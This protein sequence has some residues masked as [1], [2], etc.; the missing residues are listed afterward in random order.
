MWAW[1]FWWTVN[2]RK[3]KSK[4]SPK[5]RNPR[6][7]LT[8][9]P[10]RTTISYPP[11]SRKN[12]YRQHLREG[13]QPPVFC[14]AHITPRRS[15]W[16][17]RTRKPL[18]TLSISVLGT[19]RFW[20]GLAAAWTGQSISAGLISLPRAF[21]TSCFSLTN[22]SITMGYPLYFWPLWSRWFYGRSAT[23]AISPW[24]KCRSC[25]P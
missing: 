7:E 18:V 5:K 2:F 21:S 25:N 22:T 15:L 8:G 9:W 24:R 12:H 23:K 11:L 16:I 13:F 4:R 14:R 1:F 6:G 3:W 17:P 20:K 10:M 19:W